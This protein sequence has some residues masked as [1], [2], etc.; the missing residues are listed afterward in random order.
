MP[1]AAVI[2]YTVYKD[3]IIHVSSTIILIKGM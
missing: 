3:V 2:R 1:A